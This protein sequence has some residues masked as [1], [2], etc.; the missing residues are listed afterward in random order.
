MR[1]KI[2]KKSQMK[3]L[4]RKCAVL[5]LMLFAFG[6]LYAQDEII[7]ETEPEEQVF[8]IVEEMPV[9]KV[10]GDGNENQV[11]KYVSENL[12]YPEEARKEEIY[13]R[14][15]VQFVVNWEGYV[16]DAKVIRGVD[17][18]LDNEALRVING[19]PRWAQ[20]GMQRGNPVNVSITM[21]IN[22][23]LTND[24]DTE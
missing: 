10:G 14:V 20:P 1:N 7:E 21:P 13:G 22:F 5:G 16:K 19:M 3:L 15:F 2:L 12:Q 6:A 11:S 23:S 9:F 8:V 4:V 17:P 24:N 18:I